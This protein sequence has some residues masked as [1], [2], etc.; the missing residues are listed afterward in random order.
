MRHVHTI[1]TIILVHVCLVL[2]VLIVNSNGNLANYYT[3]APIMVKTKYLSKYTFFYFTIGICNVT[4]NQTFNCIC[5][6][7]WEGIYCELVVNFC[8]NNTC[9]NRGICRPLFRN[10]TCECLG[11][12]YFGRY[13]EHTSRKIF[14]LQIVSKS[15]A[16][17]SI[18]AISS[19]ALFVIIMDVLKYGFGI[20]PVETERKKLRREKRAKKH[21][22]AIQRFTYI[23]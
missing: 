15:F 10:F 23:A 17:I 12:H 11:N 5:D 7:G 9:Q 21:R 3:T 8:N 19:V 16:Y 4:S 2:V 1:K 13:C 6:L 22:P 14:I 18:L 20:D